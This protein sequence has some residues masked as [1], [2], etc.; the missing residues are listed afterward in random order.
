MIIKWKNS[1]PL[2]TTEFSAYPTE[3]DIYQLVRE[4]DIPK[5]LTYQKGMIVPVLP[6]HI[7]ALQLLPGSRNRV[8]YQL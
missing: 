8:V 1:I 2:Y 6:G 4:C 3:K 7:F 5:F